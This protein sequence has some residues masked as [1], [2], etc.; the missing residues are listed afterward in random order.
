MGKYISI[1]PLLMVFMAVPIQAMVPRLSVGEKRKLEVPLEKT[2]DVRTKSGSSFNEFSR[3]GERLQ[4]HENP[5][6]AARGASEAQSV[7]SG[8]SAELNDLLEQNFQ[9]AKKFFLEYLEA[10][11]MGAADAEAKLIAF[12]DAE[13]KVYQLYE[14]RAEQW[15]DVGVHP[16]DS[17]MRRNIQGLVKKSKA[18]LRL[19]PG[20]ADNWALQSQRILTTGAQREL[21]IYLQ[22]IETQGY[23]LR[24]FQSPYQIEQKSVLPLDE[25]DYDQ[26]LESLIGDPWSFLDFK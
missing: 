20:D 2:N 23:H 6:L 24:D 7:S 22:A 17:V 9:Q 10:K 3:A 14:E 11:K 21:R 12:Q 15:T 18:S 19:S 8:R 5:P 13:E 26:S 25:T 1:V 4:A 16:D